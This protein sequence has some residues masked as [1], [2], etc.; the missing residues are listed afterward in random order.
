MDGLMKTNFLS[1]M[2]KENTEAVS[3]DSFPSWLVSEGLKQEEVFNVIC[4][5]LPRNF[6][7]QTDL[8]RTAKYVNK[9]DLP[10][11][12]K[13]ELDTEQ[14]EKAPFDKGAQGLSVELSIQAS[15]QCV[16]IHLPEAQTF[17]FC[18]HTS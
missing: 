10:A 2:N 17:F 13:Q 3:L 1:T 8:F 5:L 11:Q 6:C 4:V 16:S 7:N 14:K 18:V 9:L 12:F 15:V